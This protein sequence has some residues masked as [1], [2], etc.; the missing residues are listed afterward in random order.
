LNYRVVKSGSRA[1]L[2]RE[3][4]SISLYPYRKDKPIHLVRFS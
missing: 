3:Q 1:S 2:E 4:G